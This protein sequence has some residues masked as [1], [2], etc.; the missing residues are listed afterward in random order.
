MEAGG[1]QVFV[2]IKMKQ[3]TRMMQVSRNMEEGDEAWTGDSGE[4]NAHKSRERGVR[5]HS[6]L[7]Q[8]PRKPKESR[9]SVLSLQHAKAARTRAHDIPERRACSPE[10]GEAH[11][12]RHPTRPG[13]SARVAVRA[14]A[15]RFWQGRWPPCR[16][17]GQPMH[18]PDIIFAPLP[19]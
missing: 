1:S 17:T 11:A 19:F 5:L 7:R 9:C 13:V 12:R 10:L 8:T 2:S 4:E 3:R 14:E 16:L 15:P 6:G 18:V